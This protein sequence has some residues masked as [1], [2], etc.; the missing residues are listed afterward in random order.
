MFKTTRYLKE[1]EENDWIEIE[2]GIRIWFEPGGSYCIADYW[3]IPARTATGDVEWP[4]DQHGRPL[5][6]A[7]D[8]PKHYYAPLLLQLTE[9]D[10]Q[11]CRCCVERLKCLDHPVPQ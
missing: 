6:K 3:L 2:D 11:N 8:G 1:L 9:G 5:A 10:P 7:P 4:Q